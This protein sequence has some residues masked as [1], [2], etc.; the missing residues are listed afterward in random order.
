LIDVIELLES[1]AS[2]HLLQGKP[3][4][5]V[6]SGS[7]QSGGVIPSTPE[8]DAVAREAENDEVIRELSSMHC[9]RATCFGKMDKSKE[10]TSDAQRAVALRPN[11]WRGY[12]ILAVL[13]RSHNH[14]LC[15]CYHSFQVTDLINYSIQ[16]RI[17]L[18]KQRWNINCAWIDVTQKKRRP[19]YD[20]D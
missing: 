11:W 19:R 4:N 1:I 9:N 18:I 13:V 6:G 7:P 12:S 10:A 5:R 2:P 3:L 16:R 17:C 20:L 14:H 15:M 8:V